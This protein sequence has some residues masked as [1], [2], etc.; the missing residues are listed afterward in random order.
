MNSISNS[1]LNNHSNVHT[2]TVSFEKSCERK[3]ERAL[4]ERVHTCTDFEQKQEILSIKQEN[5]NLKNRIHALET[6]QLENQPH[7]EAV[8]QMME[9][10]RRATLPLTSS[11]FINLYLIN[12][13]LI[14]QTPLN[15]NQKNGNQELTKTDDLDQT[16]Q[17]VNHYLENDK[18]NPSILRWRAGIL[19]LK[20]LIDRNF[21]DQA[22]KDI[23]LSLKIEKDEPDN[24]IIRALILIARDRLDEALEDVK[25]S[26]AIKK[27]NAFA[28]RLL[29][30][31]LNKKDQLDEA[32]KYINYSLNIKKDPLA[33]SEKAFILFRQGQLDK[34]LENINEAIKEKNHPSFYTLKNQILS[35][36]SKIKVDL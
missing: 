12:P 34:A 13:F 21:L 19:F 11:R 18:N 29:A 4:N 14:E 26:L 27:E 17:E 28:L 5:L 9:E 25:R 7:L 24:L 36:L 33:L 15:L 23:N 35:C 22:Q 20:G 32:L 1:L 8:K 3:E 10:I 31:C 2:E 16:L 30:H 6:H